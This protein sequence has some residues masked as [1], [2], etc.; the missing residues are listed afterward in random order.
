MLRSLK[1]QIYLL[2]FIPFMFIA[3]LGLYSEIS[4]TRDIETKISEMTL[5]NTL[6]IEK[7]R[8]VTIID[9]AHSL[10]APQ[11]AMP[12]DTGLKEALALINNI[13]YDNGAGYLF[14][15]DLKGV[16]LQSGSGK[17]I[18]K[19]YWS[20]QDKKG[21]Y[22]TQNII[23]AGQSGEGFTTYYFV[24]KGETVP[25]PKFS[26]SVFIP[27]WNI[28]ISTGFYIDD[29]ERAQQAIDAAVLEVVD[30]AISQAIVLIIVAFIL[31]G[32]A[33]SLAINRLYSPLH[34]L[35]DSVHSLA[36]GE[37]DLTAK[38][39]ES[40]IDLLDEIAGDF[41]TFLSAMGDDIRSLKETST[42]LRTIAH[43]SSQ[44]QMHL[45]EL[46]NQQKDE[47]AR[48][49]TAIEH[50]SATSDEIA[51][52]AG[53]T[54]E[55]ASS[56]EA[57]MQVVLQQVQV[58]NDQLDNLSDLMT[59]VAG[60][61]NE[62]GDNVSLIHSVLSVIQSISEQTNLLALNAAIEAAR[63]GEQG[64]G[65]A[66]VADE[67]RNL[68]KRSQDSTVEIKEILDKLQAS[69]VK[70]V[71]D[72]TRSDEQRVVV[73]EAMSRIREIISGSNEAIQTL[74]NLNVQV[75]DV[76]SQQSDVSSEITD[77]INGIAELA[78]DI[79]NG[80]TTAREQFESLEKQSKLISDITNKFTV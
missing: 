69:A 11:I 26:Y 54:R 14:T 72:M 74:S 7:K 28:I 1:F 30:D 80:S 5:E 39:P 52:T 31:V 27:K 71:E 3:G 10:I 78:D 55:S 24:K 50:M 65:F 6:E 4:S 66:V 79:G 58:S 57:E 76:A 44:H 25:S 9:S 61:I 29:V 68:A 60:S 53:E 42:E 40:S 32:I 67:V 45:E 13:K 75:A 15:Y 21:N 43:S 46:T 16:R 64:R 47:R 35:R 41:N 49:A 12:G 8:L 48:V 34:R 37:G 18:G 23:K 2:V 17:G 36:S 59:G 19:N 22:I 56:V 62:L 63:A 73:A 77:R 38:L 51:N 33:S 20:N 70:T